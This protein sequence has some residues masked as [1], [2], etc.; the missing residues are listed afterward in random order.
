MRF[1]QFLESKQFKVLIRKGCD[2]ITID[3]K[4]A[5]DFIVDFHNLESSISEVLNHLNIDCDKII[6][7]RFKSVQRP[8]GNFQNRINTRQRELIRR[9]FQLEARLLKETQSQPSL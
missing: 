6:L 1:D 5:V 3:N 7:P 4:L 9:A 8:S 2:L